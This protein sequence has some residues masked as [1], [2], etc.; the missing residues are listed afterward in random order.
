MKGRLWHH[1]EW[2]TW[3]STRVML[4]ASCAFS[5]IY[6]RCH[7]AVRAVK[8]RTHCYHAVADV[9]QWDEAR[10]A[11]VKLSHYSFLSVQ[12]GQGILH[13]TVE[14][15]ATFLNNFQRLIII[16]TVFV[17]ETGLLLTVRFCPS[18]KVMSVEPAAMESD[19]L[20]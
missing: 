17:P 14:N 11:C 7:K 4:N 6:R 19:M 10:H 2:L 3:K 18:D 20:Q 16:S 8:R 9:D 5:L 1:K 15:I 13:C 12:S